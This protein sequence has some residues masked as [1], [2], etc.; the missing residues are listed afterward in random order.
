ME[1]LRM[2]KNALLMG[3]QGFPSKNKNKKNTK[4]TNQSK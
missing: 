1:T 4:E 2:N 3:K